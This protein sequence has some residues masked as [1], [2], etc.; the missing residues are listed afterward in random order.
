[1][2]TLLLT[3]AIFNVFNSTVKKIFTLKFNHVFPKMIQIGVYLWSYLYI[4]Y[5]AIEY[6]KLL[7]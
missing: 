2:E 3:I 1:M 6:L 4:I 7:K 5:K